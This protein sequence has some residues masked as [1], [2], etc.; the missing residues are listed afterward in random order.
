MSTGKNRP[1]EIIDGHCHLASNR[2]IPDAFFRGVAENMVMRMQIENVPADTVKVTAM[3]KGQYND[4]QGD[5]LVAEM[6]A[7]GIG[8]TVLLAPDFTYEFGSEYS[9]EQIIQQH[10]EA[11]ERHPGRFH[12]FAGVD[13]RRG[14]S[15]VQAFASLVSSSAVAGLKLYPPCGYSPSDKR[16]YPFYEICREHRLPVLLHT[17]PT[18]AALAFSFAAAGLIDQAAKDFPSVNFILAHAGASYVQDAIAQCMYRPNVYMDISGFP[19][20]L[21]AGGWRQHLRQLFSLNLNHKIIFGTDWPVF[22]S[23]SGLS[24]LTDELFADEGP[25]QGLPKKAITQIMSGNIQRL[26]SVE[27]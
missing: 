2:C 4:H 13:P 17:G 7:A 8:S 11:A 16:L 26:L 21:A 12:I 3:L 27:Q 10:F 6:D 14:E 9:I 19:S 1:S 22:G 5:K 24:K 15:A 25:L 23:K 20:T 18:S